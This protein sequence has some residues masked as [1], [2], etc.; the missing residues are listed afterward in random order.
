VTRSAVSG[1]VA[2]RRSLASANCS[3]SR[4]PPRV[5]TS[6]RGRILIKDSESAELLRAIR[7]GATGE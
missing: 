2:V 3:W 7:Y 1:E 6:R 4:R 5:V